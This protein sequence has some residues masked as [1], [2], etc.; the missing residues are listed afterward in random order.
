MA[1]RADLVRDLVL[2]G[3][4]VAVLAWVFTAYNF[5][6]FPVIAW[7]TSAVLL[8]LACNRGRRGRHRQ[9]PRRR[10]RGRSGA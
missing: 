1:A 7:Y 4:A 10:K 3:A 6:D 5:R 8:V 2:L 9:A